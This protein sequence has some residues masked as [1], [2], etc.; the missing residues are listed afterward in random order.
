M[1]E[2]VKRTSDSIELIF[3]LETRGYAVYKRSFNPDFF[4]DRGLSGDN[5]NFDF[6]SPF[7]KKGPLVTWILDYFNKPPTVTHRLTK[8]IEW[9]P[10]KNEHS[11]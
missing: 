6:D 11:E 10:E 7:D 5:I 1:S 4:G 3:V 2:S 8:A 9:N